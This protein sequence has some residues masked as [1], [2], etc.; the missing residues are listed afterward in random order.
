MKDRFATV[1]WEDIGR[2]KHSLANDMQAIHKVWLHIRDYHRT[3]PSIQEAIVEGVEKEVLDFT[4]IRLKETMWI[5]EE[6]ILKND[7]RK[8]SRRVDNDRRNHKKETFYVD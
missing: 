7:R 8:V 4:S 3:D 2:L 1:S 6:I 5:L